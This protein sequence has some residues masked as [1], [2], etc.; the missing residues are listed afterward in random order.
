MSLSPEFQS[1]KFLFAKILHACRTH[2]SCSIAC[3]TV[4]NDTVA[5]F[6]NRL[7]SNIATWK[8]QQN[9]TTDQYIELDESEASVHFTDRRYQRNQKT[10]QQRKICFVCRK[11]GCWSTRHPDSERSQAQKRLRDA[12]TRKNNT[13]NQNNY[14]RFVTDANFDENT[15]DAFIQQYEG[16]DPDDDQPFVDAFDTFLTI[17]QNSDDVVNHISDQFFHT[18]CGSLDI[19]FAQNTTHEINTGITRHVLTRQVEDLEIDSNT[20][21]ISK[22]RFN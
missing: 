2:P 22:P 4:A 5:T 19:K 20:F 10:N 12:Y 16:V 8:S 11:E 14:R 18:Q 1:D 7:H 21:A 15:I 3:S 13:Y 17:K 6:V 9:F